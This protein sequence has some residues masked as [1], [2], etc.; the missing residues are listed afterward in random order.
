[1]QARALATMVSGTYR[2]FEHAL[3]AG[4][5]TDEPYQVEFDFPD[6][7]TAGYGRL[8]R[9]VPMIT[10]D[11]DWAQ[12]DAEERSATRAEFPVEHI[13]N[14]VPLLVLFLVSTDTVAPHIAS[15]KSYVADSPVGFPVPRR[16]ALSAKSVNPTVPSSS[17]RNVPLIRKPGLASSSKPLSSTIKA[18]VPALLRRPS[19]QTPLPITA[20][21]KPKWGAS[22]TRESLSSR[23]GASTPRLSVASNGRM[24]FG[25][26][27]IAKKSSVSSLKQASTAIVGTPAEEAAL[28]I[29]G[30]TTEELGADFGFVVEHEDLFVFAE[31]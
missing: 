9:G 31:V 5:F 20:S 23:S 6:Y 1:M 22:S 19:S 21:S 11:D 24:K 3:I 26:E 14:F 10:G 13:C 16:I 12:R 7:K 8:L 17:T 28:G 4:V 27:G 30:I 15:T 2:L 18:K 25:S 29:F